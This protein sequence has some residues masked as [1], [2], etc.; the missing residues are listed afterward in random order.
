MINLGI[1][2]FGGIARG[3]HIPQ[4]RQSGKFFLRAVADIAPNQEAVKRLEIPTVYTDYRDLLRDSTID[5]VLIASPHDLHLEHCLAAFEAGKHVLIEKP[6]SRNLEEA[7]KIIAAAE[8]AGSVAMLGFC[9]RF[10]PE[11]AYIKQ[12]LNNNALGRL[13]SA[14]VDHYQNFKPAATSWWRNAEKVGG[15]AVIGSGIHRLDLLRWYLGE[16]VCVYAKAVHTDKRLGAE[17]CAHAVIEF[18]S[19][20]IANFSINWACYNYLYYEGLSISGEDGLVVTGPANKLGL[21]QVD[22][23]KLKDFTPP[24][25]PTMYE[26]FASCIETGQTPI[27]SLNEGYHSLQLVRAV[28]ESIKTQAPVIPQNIDF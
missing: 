24:K 3:L 7:R 17:A 8:K 15:G 19:G 21:A 23:G 5:A 10:T 27:T 14:R 13:L 4:A 22:G 26:H 16:P 6:I 20:V 11:H 18:D 28:Y 25:C 2:G 9:E 12:L 1:I